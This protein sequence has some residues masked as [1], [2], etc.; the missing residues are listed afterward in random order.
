MLLTSTRF[1]IDD[2]FAQVNALGGLV[3][4]A[5]VDQTPAT[6]SSPPSACSLTEWPILALEIS[7][8]ITPEKARANFPAIGRYPLIQSGDVHRLDEFIGTTIFKLEKPTMDEIRMALKNEGG[9]DVFIENMPD[10]LHP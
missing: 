8:H 2:V 10:K 3:I 1:S 4:P 6:V 9:R 5:H 7:R